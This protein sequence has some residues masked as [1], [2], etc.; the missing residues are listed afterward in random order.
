MVYEFRKTLFVMLVGLLGKR[1][2][3]KPLREFFFLDKGELDIQIE[4]GL[5]IQRNL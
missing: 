5:Q 1:W 4:P 3:R 2:P